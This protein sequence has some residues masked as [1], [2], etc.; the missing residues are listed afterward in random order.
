MV[1]SPERI[2]DPI[3]IVS[4]ST[5][6]TISYVLT[7]STSLETTI[8]ATKSPDIALCDPR[9][10]QSRIKGGYGMRKFYYLI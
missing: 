1:L 8:Q 7:K 5:K 4:I 2:K 6:H 10:V 9:P 3:R